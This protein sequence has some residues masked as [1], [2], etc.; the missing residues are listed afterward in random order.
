MRKYLCRPDRIDTNDKPF[1]TS[2]AGALPNST[3]NRANDFPEILDQG[4]LG[5]CV[6]YS[7]AAIGQFIERRK[8]PIQAYY[9]LDPE[10]L[11]Y[12]AREFMGTTSWDSGAYIRDAL[13][14][15]LHNGCCTISRYEGERDFRLKPP[16]EA[17]ENASGH[18]IEAYY[19]IMTKLQLQQALADGIPIAAGMEI[20][21]SFE[22]DEVARTGYVPMPDKSKEYVLGGHAVVFM[23][24]TPTHIVG[25]NSW[26][27]DWG[28]QGYFYLPWEFLGRYITDMWV[29]K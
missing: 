16:P 25:R 7:V 28:D 3:N 5:A 20:W 11:Y 2:R 21:S 29:V 17:D 6:G 10:Y 8:S 22:S 18:K 4:S 14:V 27:K 1:K 12:K 19:R 13:S 23:D 15:L 24:Y 26:G 9:Y